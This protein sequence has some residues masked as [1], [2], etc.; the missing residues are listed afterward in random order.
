MSV[1]IKPAYQGLLLRAFPSMI[2]SFWL[3]LQGMLL[4]QPVS[5]LAKIAAEI[6]KATTYLELYWHP[7]VN[8]AFSVQ[9]LYALRGNMRKAWYPTPAGLC[10]EDT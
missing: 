2:G 6:G 5:N 9:C 3:H 1:L 8:D 10:L 7:D 4:V